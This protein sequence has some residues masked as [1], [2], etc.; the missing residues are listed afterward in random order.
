MFKLKSSESEHESI[1]YPIILIDLRK[2]KFWTGARIQYFKKILPYLNA[3]VLLKTKGNCDLI[4]W[5]PFA[6]LW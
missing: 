6:G 5:N 4:C 1:N 3:V 2:C